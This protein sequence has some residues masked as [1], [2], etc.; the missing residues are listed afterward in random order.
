MM[1]HLQ[2]VQC[3]IQ[4]QVGGFLIYFLIISHISRR[5]VGECFCHRYLHFTCSWLNKTRSYR[6]AHSQNYICTVWYSVVLAQGLLLATPPWCV[7]SRISPTELPTAMRAS[8]RVT[9]RSISMYKSMGKS[10]WGATLILKLFGS[11]VAME[12]NIW[13]HTVTRRPW[14]TSIPIN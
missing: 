5:Y 13:V 3:T 9:V 4:I 6:Q 8:C 14:K 11:P 1:Y 7:H 2:P 12:N 10:A